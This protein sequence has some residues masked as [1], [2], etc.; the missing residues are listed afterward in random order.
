MCHID[1]RECACPTGPGTDLPGGQPVP[2]VGDDVAEGDQP[3]PA[4]DPVTD[5]FQLIA[6]IIG[7]RELVYLDAKEIAEMQGRNEERGLFFL[8]YQD[9]VSPVPFQAS[10]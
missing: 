7:K 4:T 8:G 1:E 9:P 5:G 3:G 10:R 6:R 2:R